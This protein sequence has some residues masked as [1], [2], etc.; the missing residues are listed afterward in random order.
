MDQPRLRE[1]LASVY[2]AAASG[3]NHTSK[4]ETAAQLDS[5]YD[6][7]VAQWNDFQT[8][9]YVAGYEAARTLNL[10]YREAVFSARQTKAINKSYQRQPDLSD[11]GECCPYSDDDFD[12]LKDGSP[13]D[14]TGPD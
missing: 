6:Q 12:G 2:R 13:S 8:T 1:R 7:A 14:P 3:K 4:K 11:W 5:I 9:D 10:N